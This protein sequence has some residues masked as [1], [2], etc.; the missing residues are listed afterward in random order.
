MTQSLD[1]SRHL[2]RTAAPAALA[3]AV[4]LL[5]LILCAFYEPGLGLHWNP[6]L[7]LRSYLYS[8]L[9]WLGISL[10]SMGV[11]MMHHL[12]GGGWGFLIRRFGES[13]GWLM[14]VLV[15]LFIP[16]ILGV[17]WL[18]PWAQS[19]VLANDAV[20]RHKAHAFLNWPAW[21]IRSVIYLAVF[22]IMGWRLRAGSF[23]ED[24]NPSETLQARFRRFSAGGEVVYVVVMTLAGIDWIMS[25]EPHWYSTIFG[26]IVVISQA[27]SALCVLT[28]VV[29][30][31]AD[32]DPLKSVIHPNYLNDLGNVI[33]CFVVLWAYLSFAQFLVIWLGNSQDE[34][35][36]YIGRTTG[37]W[38]AVGGAL[39]LLHFLVPFIL[40]LQRPM[41]RKLD[42]LAAVAAFLLVMR[43]VDVAYWVLPTGVRP[44]NHGAFHAWYV[45]VVTVLAFVAVSGIC[46]A[47]FAWLTE[48]TPLLPVGAHVPDFKDYGEGPQPTPTAVP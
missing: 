7:E 33:L 29:W 3:G 48:R 15:L 32:R 5:L 36:W 18:Y 40:L 13:A 20:L 6:T 8:W 25:R 30:L 10:G 27:L 1:R 34:I 35:T 16:I 45:I 38:R 28:I 31:F 14:P 37:G 9:F 42:R 23:A 39:I 22:T 2:T 44:A 47:A 19:D 26:F 46:I 24:R 21:S 11:V 4:C 43:A 12:L 17:H 41:K